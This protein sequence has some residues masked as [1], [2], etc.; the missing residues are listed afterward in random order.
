M[1]IKNNEKIDYLKAIAIILVIL[2]HSMSYYSK[3]SDVS[4]LYRLIQTLIFSVHVPLFF[5]I[6]GFLCHKQNK[7]KF[8]NKKIKRILIPFIT[9]TV[10]KLVYSNVISGEF[11]HSS[12]F[13]MQIVDAFLFGSLYWFS[14]AILLMY[15]I[16]CLFWNIKETKKLEKTI[17]IVGTVAMIYSIIINIFNISLIPNIFQINKTIQYF[18]YFLFG[19]YLNVSNKIQLLDKYKI[20]LNIITTIVILICSVLYYKNIISDC[21]PIKYVLAF[22]LMFVLKEIVQYFP[23]NLNFLKKIGLYSYQLMLFDSFYK[24]IL[25]TI[26]GHFLNINVLF[27]VIIAIINL[28][29]GVIS[30]EIVKRIPRINTLFG[31]DN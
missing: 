18:P 26:I 6:S 28:L 9:F 20:S 3:M 12:N 27:V 5:V 4:N 10:L 21:L 11:V 15:L 14:Y 22:S 23:K 2:G 8:I 17:I 30:S 24:V 1:K 31:L 16:I 7:R 29:L 13:L 25:F 19:Y